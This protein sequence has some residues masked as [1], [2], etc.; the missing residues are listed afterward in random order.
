VD[1]DGYIAYVAALN[2][3]LR[4]G[5][6]QEHNANVL[7]WQALGPRPEGTSYG[8]EFCKLMGMPVPPDKGDYFVDLNQFMKDRLKIDPKGKE[9]EKNWSLL[10]RISQRPWTSKEHPDFGAWLEANDKPLAVTVEATKRTQYY[11]PVV[12]SKGGKGSGGLITALL[13]APQKCRGLANALVARAMFR[14]GEGKYDEA[15][16]DLL[17]CH[18]LGQLVGHGGTLIEGLIGISI[19]FIA[20]RADLAFLERV[21]TDAKRIESSL[22]DLQKLP[23]FPEL[24][25][26]IILGERFSILDTIQ[27]VDRHGLWYLEAL[28]DGHAKDPQDPLAKEFAEGMRKAILENI[29]WDPAMRNAN[30][31]FDRMAAAARGRDRPTREKDWSWIESDLKTLRTNL[32][33]SQDLAKLLDFNDHKA[34]GKVLG[35]MIICLMTPAIHNVQKAVDRTKQTQDN[36]YVAFA[37]ARYHCDHGQYPKTL[38]ALAPK[39]LKQ[40]PEDIFA[41]KPLIYR[42]SENGYLLYSVG[43]NG[44]DDGGHGGDD[45]PK[46]DDL[47]IRMPLPEIKQK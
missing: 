47:V 10:E 8:P 40:I 38:D 31:L 32:V 36:L 33:D 21:Q 9:A 11:S 44:K 14:L 4:Q 23:P 42:S 12:V 41:G 18:R 27:M 22:G 24:T 3:R 43:V 16:Q 20:F 35:D 1:K 39:Y 15:W 26:K 2:E 19:E 7:L 28:S 29:E 34:R 46:G 13:P 30:L 6:M 25:D 37:L 45:E 17:A 5:V